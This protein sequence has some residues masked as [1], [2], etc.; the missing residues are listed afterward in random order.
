[1]LQNAF[2]STTW[3]MKAV[4]TAAIVL[5]LLNVALAVQVSFMTYSDAA[6]GTPQQAL[7][8]NPFICKLNDCCLYKVSQN[9]TYLKA[10]S[11]SASVTYSSA[12]TDA[13]C[14]QLGSA[15]TTTVQANSCIST[16]PPQSPF[17]I[18]SLKI[19]CSSTSSASLG[20]LAVLAAA[21]TSC[22]SV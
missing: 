19:T 13:A 8:S 20:L 15:S 14:T 2:M 4:I 11:C 21:L 18:G 22:L 1:V 10:S 3:N 16:S 12:Y 17:F 7:S 5:T 6:C 9:M